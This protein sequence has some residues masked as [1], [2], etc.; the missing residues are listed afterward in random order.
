MS[1]S[2]AAVVA[3][4]T[5]LCFSSAC[6]SPGSWKL[7]RVGVLLWTEQSACSRPGSADRQ[8]AKAKSCV[9]FLDHVVRASRSAR[10]ERSLSLWACLP[11]IQ[12]ARS[13]TPVSHGLRES[14]RSSAVPGANA[15]RQGKA[16]LILESVASERGVRL[17]AV[18][19]SWS[20]TLTAVSSS[21]ICPSGARHCVTGAGRAN[22]RGLQGHRRA[23]G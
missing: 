19:M 13:A 21:S 16:Y 11:R 20:K 5:R 3:V 14:R 15:T 10:L 22:H 17:A 4:A 1:Q 7:T 8:S 9:N 12:T 6:D 2:C 18:S 23:C